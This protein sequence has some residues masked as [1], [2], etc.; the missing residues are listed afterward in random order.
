MC[1]VGQEII[2][3]REA[4]GTVLSHDITEVN[5]ENGFKGAR[6]RRG[7]VISEEDVEKLLDL[8]KEHLY[9]LEINED[10][11][12]END[13]AQMM[14]TAICGNNAMFTPEPSEGKINI[15][16]AVDGLLKVDVAALESFNG[17]GAVMCAARH[18][19]TVVKKGD[20]IAGTR[21]IPLVVEKKPVHD[22]VAIAA[23][24]GGIVSVLPL[25]QA[26]VALVITGNEVYKGR[27]KDAFEP[28]IRKKVEDLGST[29]VEVVKSPDNVGVI[30]A[31]LEQVKGNQADL[32]VMT[33]GMS[34]DP[35]D[36]TPLA[37][38]AAGAEITAYGSA[39]LPGTMF[40]VGYFKNGTPVL[41]VPACGIHHPRTIFDLVLPRV[42]AGETITDKDIARLGH[43]GMCLDCPECN[44]PVCPFGKGS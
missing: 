32:V 21:A 23:G 19:N 12:H 31:A 10:Q 33:G 25:K 22:A 16:S 27:I 43:G 11:M 15:S 40:M 13:A 8:G 7:H 30:R 38:R 18:S 4:V 6:F 17:V 28:V 36:V 14:A 35:D 3:V 9:I 24:A 26:R 20:V 29:V 1:E 5:P 37:A 34:V 2:A 39:V 41:G 44:F 42:L